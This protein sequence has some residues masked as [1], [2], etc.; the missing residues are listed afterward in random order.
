VKLSRRKEP[1]EAEVV[2]PE[3]EIEP[4]PTGTAGKGRPT[5]KRRD[6]Q[7]RRGPVTAPKT[8]KE[9]YARQKQLAKEQKSAAP[10]AKPRTVAEQRAALR[11]GD[12]SA[13]PRRDQGPTRKL[14]RDYVDS[15]R[16]LSNYLLWLFP[17][18]IVTT[19]VRALFFLQMLILVV[20]VGLLIEWY[21]TG[22]RI[23]NMAIERFGSAEGGNMTIGFYAGS[24][25]YLPRK[26]RLP[27]PQV[28]LGE[29][30]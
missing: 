20:F 19:F 2:E 10:A 7:G 30:I 16:M 15:H 28:S 27:K 14:A 23:R 4:E 9:A 3:P 18:M 17:L 11:R 6:S 13:L 21:L 8:R 22:R 29:K 24:R 25:A 5:P 1:A 26:W 12:P